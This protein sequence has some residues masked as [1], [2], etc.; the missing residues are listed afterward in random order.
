MYLV[1]TTEALRRIALPFHCSTVREIFYE[2]KNTCYFIY[3]LRL[4][5]SLA[6]LLD[7]WQQRLYHR[8]TVAAAEDS[9]LRKVQKMNVLKK[10]KSGTTAAVLQLI[11]HCLVALST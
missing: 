9:T 4:Q 5:Q 7:R 6:G 1:L 3:C 2:T 10:E 8:K 11:I